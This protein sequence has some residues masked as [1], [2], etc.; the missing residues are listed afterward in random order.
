[1]E[2]KSSHKSESAEDIVP[3][4]L[5]PAQTVCNERN[6]KG[7]LCNGNIKQQRTGGEPVKRH[8]RGDDVVFKCQVCGTLY[9]GPPLGHVRDPEK[10]SRYVQKELTDLLEAAGGTLPAFAPNERGALVQVNP[11]VEQGHATPAPA[12]PAQ[13]PQNSSPSADQHRPEAEAQ[14]ATGKP[15]AVPMNPSAATAVEE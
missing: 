8:L 3:K 11:P 1:M 12:K 15:S 5:N 9:I 10:M 13:A 14:A 7:K 2:S 6:E 4:R